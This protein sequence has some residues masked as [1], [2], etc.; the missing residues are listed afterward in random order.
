[1]LDQIGKLTH[2]NELHNR[3]N[4]LRLQYIDKTVPN[5]VLIRHHTGFKG[6]EKIRE[7]IEN[8]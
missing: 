3:Y 2:I 6:K 1:M 5:E 7:I 8:D 4:V